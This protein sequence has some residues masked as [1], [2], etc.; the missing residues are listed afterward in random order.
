MDFL[1][2]RGTCEHHGYLW[3]LKQGVKM[4]KNMEF[5]SG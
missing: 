4:D 3:D 2:M 5:D 1:E